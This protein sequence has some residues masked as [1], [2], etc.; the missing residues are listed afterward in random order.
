LNYLLVFLGGGAGSIT[1]FFLS[2]AVYQL[3]GSLF[4]LGT[5]IINL[6]GCLFIGFLYGLFD[7]TVFPPNIRVFC[8]VGFLGGYT[9]F[10]SFGLE[11]VNLIIGRE[12]SLAFINI[13]ASNIAG[14]ALVYT[15]MVLSKL[16]FIHHV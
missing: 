3:T 15:G 13:I 1:R 6:T 11:S 2:K 16:A 14:L 8:L 10:S 12:I 5:L 9:T 4:P 7:S